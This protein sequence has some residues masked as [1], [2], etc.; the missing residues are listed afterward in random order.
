MSGTV[1]RIDLAL[2]D[3]ADPDERLLLLEAEHPR[4]RRA[5]RDDMDEIVLDG[6][7][8]KPRLH[9][10]LHE[11]VAERLRADD[12][13]EVWA[14]AQRLSALGYD[15]HEVCTCSCPC[16]A[17]NSTEQCKGRR[18]RCRIQARHGPRWQ[19]SRELGDAARGGTDEPGG[20][21]STAAHSPPA[22]QLTPR[23]E[24]RRVLTAS[25]SNSR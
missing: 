21:A 25:S 4:L 15:R 9:L 7:L 24:R 16:S 13:P 3:A 10:A 18:R 8:M 12:P 19:S 6:Q 20:A 2:P 11:V 22:S 23:L 1:D 14:T 17:T 5:L